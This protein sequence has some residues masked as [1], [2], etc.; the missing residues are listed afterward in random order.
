MK[1]NLKFIND[2]AW[3]IVA[4]HNF[5]VKGLSVAKSDGWYTFNFED[6][7][8]VHNINFDTYHIRHYCD[9]LRFKTTNA[10]LHM[11]DAIIEALEGIKCDTDRS[12][13]A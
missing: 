9:G 3:K 12:V 8:G 7:D 10:V 5:P 13:Q 1:P 4:N 2:G 11:M 6:D